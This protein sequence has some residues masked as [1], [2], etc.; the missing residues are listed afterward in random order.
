MR[1][2]L[3]V[4]GGIIGLTAAI[5]LTA[6]G[7]DVA[8]WS[9]VD[10]LDTVSAVAAAVWYPT[11]TAADPRVLRWAA[12]TYDE[13]TR[14][15][16]AG[17]PGVLLRPTRN[18]GAATGPPWW[19]PAA[20]EVTPAAPVARRGSDKSDVVGMRHGGNSPHRR[21]PRRRQ[22]AQLRP[23]SDGIGTRLALDRGLC[24]PSGK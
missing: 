24:W 11:R 7:A 6:A 15:A 9:P 20:G 13:F 18:L 4:G 22:L 5:R 14:Q 10:P 21:R 2:V 8:V 16:A 17:V 19:V 12:D 1:D 3:V 23:G